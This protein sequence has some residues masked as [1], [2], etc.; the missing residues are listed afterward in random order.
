MLLVP[1]VTKCNPGIGMVKVGFK[2]GPGLA[3]SV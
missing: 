2:P 1:L 3:M